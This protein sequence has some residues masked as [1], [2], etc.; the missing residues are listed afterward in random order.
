M[1]WKKC[2]IQETVPALT[3][4]LIIVKSYIYVPELGEKL[5]YYDKINFTINK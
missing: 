3:F 1:Q 4:D 5:L 2:S